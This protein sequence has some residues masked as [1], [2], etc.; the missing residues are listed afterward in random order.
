V[1]AKK[2]LAYAVFVV[3]ITPVRI[4]LKQF[5]NPYRNIRLL[6]TALWTL[7][8]LIDRKISMDY[9]Q[10]GAE[11]EQKGYGTAKLLKRV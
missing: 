8:H 3:F 5:P 9:K 6:D 2:P 1:K 11:D 10:E 7:P 4:R